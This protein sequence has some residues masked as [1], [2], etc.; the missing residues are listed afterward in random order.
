M[1]LLLTFDRYK[2][3]RQE[4]DCRIHPYWQGKAERIKNPSGRL[5]EEAAGFLAARMEQM[6][7]IELD[8]Y[9]GE[10]GKPRHKGKEPLYFNISHTRG[11]AVLAFR[12]SSEIGIDT[13][14]VRTAPEAVERRYFTRQEQ[15]ICGGLHDRERDL[16]FFRIWTAKEACMKYTGSGIVLSPEKIHTEGLFSG[17]IQGGKVAEKNLFPTA[18]RELCNAGEV[19][20]FSEDKEDP[21]TVRQ[22]GFTPFN[23]GAAPEYVVSVAGGECLSDPPKIDIL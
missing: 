12:F 18:V 4:K 16:A 13:E 1:I 9:L 6:T 19:T 17:G 14:R 7:G 11:L 21:F 8:L 22:Y 20:C 15:D 5:Q 3:L 10:R 2:A 23:G